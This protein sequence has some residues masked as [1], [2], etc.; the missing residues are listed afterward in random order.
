[1]TDYLQRAGRVRSQAG[2]SL[3]LYESWAIASK[4]VRDSWHGEAPNTKKPDP[5]KGGS[6]L[7]L[8]KRQRLQ[9]CILDYVNLPTDMLGTA[10][11]ETWC[12]RLQIIQYNGFEE[13]PGMALV[14]ALV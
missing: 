5:S 9:P 6:G 11:E 4:T 2:I 8:T 14:T 7:P 3:L 1:M 13:A 12:R 10:A